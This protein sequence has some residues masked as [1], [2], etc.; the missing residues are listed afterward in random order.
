RLGDAHR[1]WRRVHRALKRWHRELRRELAIA[2]RVYP[3]VLERRWRQ[4]RARIDKAR[5]RIRG[6]AKLEYAWALEAHKDGWPHIHECL[7]LDWLEFRWARNEW[8]RCLGVAKAHIDGRVVWDVEGTCRYLS[9][10]IAKGGLTPEILA[11]LRRRRAWAS[12]V[13]LPDI[14]DTG[15][16]VED[17]TRSA[18]LEVQVDEREDW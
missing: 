14:P 17:E 5:S 13:P 2:H 16:W 12:T 18:E 1:A 6:P 7:N 9:K 4:R 15:Y 11:L 8:T 10:Y 3:G